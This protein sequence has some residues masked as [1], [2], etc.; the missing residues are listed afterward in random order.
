MLAQAQSADARNAAAQTQQQMQQ[1]MRGPEGAADDAEEA[2]QFTW[3]PYAGPQVAQ[4]SP[5]ERDWEKERRRIA[6][7]RPRR[8]GEQEPPQPK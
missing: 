2:A 4:H 1:V 6:L 5:E 7:M 8:A 3:T